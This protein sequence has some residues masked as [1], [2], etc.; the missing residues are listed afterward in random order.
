MQTFAEII[1]LLTNEISILGVKPDREKLNTILESNKLVLNKEDFELL[2]NAIKN[3]LS[4]YGRL[5][6][7][8]S[9]NTTDLVVNNAQTVWVDYGNGL[10]LFTDVFENDEDVAFL[11]R[12]L[13]ALAT[14]RLDDVQPYVDGMLPDG[15]RLHALL[16]PIS[17]YCAKISLRFPS[18]KIIPLEAW[19]NGLKESENEILDKV[20]M[21]DASFLIAGA[22]GSG[23]TTLLKS[24]LNSRPVNQ[25]ILILEETAEIQLNKPNL[26]SLAARSANTEGLGT[27]SLQQLV[28][29][30]L[31]MRP[32]SIIIG[33]IRGREVLDFLLAISSGHKGSGST[34]HAKPGFVQERIGLLCRLAGIDQNFGIEL[35]KSSIDVVIHCQT[36]DS[37]RGIS[38]I[39]VNN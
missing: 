6:S 26:V 30:S 28:R 36:T 33:E 4:G 31:R 1:Q 8:I 19:R 22:T 16:P 13:A 17:G 35:F 9:E 3:E 14:A 11:A 27:L 5:T 25:R 18:Q 12:R 20:V 38:R 29:Q 10:Q 2:V 34:I 39:E 21:G 24:I 37:K 7:L 23:K 15:V 32:D